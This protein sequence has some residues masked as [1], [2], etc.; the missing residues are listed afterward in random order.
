[1]ILTHMSRR[2]K[3]LTHLAVFSVFCTIL[4]VGRLRYFAFSGGDTQEALF[5]TQ[6]HMSG[7]LFLL[8]NMMLAWVPYI[9]S[10]LLPYI[11]RATRDSGWAL[12]PT[13]LTWFLFFPNAPYLATD[14]SHITERMATSNP[15]DLGLYGFTSILGLLLSFA[16]L[17]EVQRFFMTRVGSVLSWM[18]TMMAIFF[19]S[20]GIYLGKYDGFSSWD[21]FMAP[22]QY[23]QGLIQAAISP[24]WSQIGLT[25]GIATFLT[26]GYMQYF[27]YAFD[28]L[29][30][31][32]DSGE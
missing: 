2:L 16:S 4:V 3:M 18:G 26:F 24:T 20:F 7:L 19:C 25:F 28:L 23:V 30:Y 17:Y 13:I 22:S 11:A 12:I 8:W 31:R 5:Q 27:V 21:V 6:S 15:Y 1:M 29:P 10:M 14:L 32:D 9:I